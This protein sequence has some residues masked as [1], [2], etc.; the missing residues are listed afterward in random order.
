[1]AVNVY[2]KYNKCVM[3][4]FPTFTNSEID[5]I[6]LYI[7]ASNYISNQPLTKIFICK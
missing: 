7:E 2:N 4:A 6:L 3:T 1:M 5:S